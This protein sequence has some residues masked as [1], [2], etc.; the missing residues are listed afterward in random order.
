MPLRCKPNQ[1]CRVIPSRDKL[2]NHFVG[3][4]VL[5]TR[6]DPDPSSVCGCGSPAWFYAPPALRGDVTYTGW[7]AFML[8]GGAA[9]K[10]MANVEILAIYDCCL[11][12]L[13]DD[14]QAP[15]EKWEPAPL[16]TIRPKQ[17]EHS[18]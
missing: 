6:L 9:D 5:T 11:E 8:S 1:L 2:L 12:P 16:D 15:E 18:S 14:D 17:P 7:E 13:P 4:V 3:R 10:V